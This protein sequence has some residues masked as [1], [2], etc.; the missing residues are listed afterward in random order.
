MATTGMPDGTMHSTLGFF[1]II[2][3]CEKEL[4]SG[5]MLE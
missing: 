4:N 2:L 3:P 1:G 5:I